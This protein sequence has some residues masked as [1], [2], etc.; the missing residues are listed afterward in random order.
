MQAL[1]FEDPFEKPRSYAAAKAYVRI[2]EYSRAIDT[3]RT[4]LE[5]IEPVKP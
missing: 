1:E 4:M 2:G 5:R 3:A